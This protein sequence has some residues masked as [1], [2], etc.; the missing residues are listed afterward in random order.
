MG[1]DIISAGAILKIGQR[2]AF[3]SDT[4]DER[5]T[6]RIEDLSDTE[7]VVAMPMDS[8]R[9]PIIPMTGQHLYGMVLANQSQYRFFTVFHK[10]GLNGGIP[11]WWITK[12][13]KLER[14]QNRAF[15][16]VR[17]NLPIQV[18]AMD[19]EGGFLPPKMTQVIDLSG[20]GVSFVFDEPL[21]I[22]S[23]VILEVRNIP[24]I[25]TLQIMG[26]IM[27]CSPVEMGGGTRK[28]QIG[29]H[30]MNLTRPMR[31]RLV[32]YIFDVQRQELAKGIEFSRGTQ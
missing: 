18:Q 19:A 14:L 3:F 10:K 8:K 9:R 12:P 26:R 15:V 5:Y 30:M 22:D 2:M 4:S 20:S 1:G 11:C 27:R 16:R 32:H 24:E 31:N 13:D 7:M 25:G 28:Y 6:S 21:K 23:Q 17:V 29:A